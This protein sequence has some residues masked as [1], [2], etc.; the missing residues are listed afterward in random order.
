M[1]GQEL[2]VDARAVVEALELRGRTNLEQVL[3]ADLVL[4]QQQ[5]VVTLAI[6]L[7]IAIG[8]APLGQVR[9]DAD[10]RL[11]ADLLAGPIEL[12]RRVHGPVVR[13]GERWHVQL[14]RALGQLRDAAQPVQ[15]R[16][17]AM[18]VQMNEVG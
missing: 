9:L 5:Q 14:A 10:D 2:M 7:G 18:H 6:D 16:I 11:D 8:H 15:Q 1:G 13:D 17:F 4:R 12:D 3:I